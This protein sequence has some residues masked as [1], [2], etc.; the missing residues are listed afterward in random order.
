MS[1]GRENTS[2]LSKSPEP[3]ARR[4]RLSRNRALVG[5]VAHFASRIPRFAVDRLMSVSDVSELRDQAAPRISWSVLF[6]K[7]YSLVAADCR[8]LRQA[9]LGWPWGHLIEMPRSVG[10]V[11]VNRRDEE[12]DEDRLCWGRFIRPEKQSLVELQEALDEYQREPIAEVF[13][14]QMQHSKWPTA[15]RRLVWWVNLNLVV[16]N[17]ARRVG[18]FS[19]SSL[20][21]Q[22]AWNRSHPTIHTTSLTFGPL[23]EQDRILVTLICDHRVLDGALAARVLAELEIALRGPI[24]AE[25]AMLRKSREAA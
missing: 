2:D 20:A 23:D 10:M 1:G 24:A 14:R 18:T 3:R 21:G 4:V 11:A 22:G 6:L 17:R 5:D 7:A 12:L 8:A 15:L 16:K 25:L 9:Y 13:R 19:M